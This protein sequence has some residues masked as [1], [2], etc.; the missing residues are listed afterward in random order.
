MDDRASSQPIAAGG[1]PAGSTIWNYWARRYGQITKLGRILDPFADKII[2]CGTFV[3][4]A[5]VPPVDAESGLDSSASEVW[6]WMAVVV[7]AREILVT[8]LRSFFEEHG[9]DFSA[10]WAGKWKMVF[11]CLAAGLSLWRLWYY[12]F[13]PSV[14]GWGTTPAVW[15]TWTLRLAV[16]VAIAMT[17]YSGWGYVHNALRMLKR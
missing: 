4:L 7:I 5:A 13:D 6:A 3:F 15:S 16:W 17:I 11:Q 14:L 12:E 9:T 1:A 8:A 2:I 10:Q